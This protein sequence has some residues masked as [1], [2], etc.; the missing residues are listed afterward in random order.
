[1][2]DASA[3]DGLAHA[4]TYFMD[5]ENPPT[6]GKRILVVEDE[7]DLADLICYN[8]EREGY[9]CRSVAAGNLVL[10]EIRQQRPDLVLLDRMLPGLSGDEVV[11]QLKR[12][13]ATANIPIILL[14]AKAEESDQLVGFALGADDYV[15]KPF[16][17][18]VL[19]ARVTALLRR[20]ESDS[21]ADDVL[22]AGPLRLS[23]S[24]H[25]VTLHGEPVPLTATEF[26]LLATLMKAQGRV[27]DRARLIDSVL[28]AE[29]IV[30]DRTI[31]VHV[32]AVRRKLR[33]AAEWVQTVR[34][35]G[36]TFRQPAKSPTRKS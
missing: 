14:T 34:G 10:D 3:A 29:T 13:S 27:L 32:T 35:V 11:G 33:A 4:V 6:P 21:P 8:M 24:H 22:E 12:N 25:Q 36:Y 9:E 26:R 16:S 30:T 19:L 2:A 20:L 17:M 5:K 7:T 1:M 31:D 28:G 18:K 23:T 15:S